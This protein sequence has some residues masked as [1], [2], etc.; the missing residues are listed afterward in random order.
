MFELV[1]MTGTGMIVTAVAAILGHFHIVLDND[2][3]T[4]LVKD[5]I[6]IGGIVLMV[7]G[8]LRRKDLVAGVI[9]K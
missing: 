9:R 4:A 6:E 2:T 5:I 3:I 7:I 8:Q 1:S